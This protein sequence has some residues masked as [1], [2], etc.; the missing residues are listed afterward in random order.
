M[1]TTARF[2][3]VSDFKTWDTPRGSINITYS[4]HSVVITGY[5]AG[6]IY[7]NDPYGTKNKQLGREAFEKAWKQMGSQ[8]IVIR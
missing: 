5:D 1:I 3:P 2:Q 8:A 4:E 6:H 7:V